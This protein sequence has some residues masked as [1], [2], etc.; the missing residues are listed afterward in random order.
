MPAARNPSPAD[1]LNTN[2]TIHSMEFYMRPHPCEGCIPGMKIAILIVSG[3]HEEP[4][5]CEGCTPGIK[6]TIL[7]MSG[8]HEEPQP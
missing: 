2:E 7:A 4:H 6:L 1:N 3:E 8:E 5:P